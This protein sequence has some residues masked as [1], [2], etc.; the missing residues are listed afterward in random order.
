[1]GTGYQ[2]KIVR[3]EPLDEARRETMQEAIRIELERV[4]TAMSTYL[5][6][7]EL[8][9]WNASTETTPFE[10]SRPTWEVFDIALEA[11][12]L[13]GGALD[14][15]VGPLV[16]AWGFGPMSDPSAEEPSEEELRAIRERIGW[17]KLE[18]LEEPRAIRKT[19]PDLYCDLSA[20]AKGYAVDRVAE[21]LLDLGEEDFMVEVGGE[22]R[23]AGL[24]GLGSPWRIGIERPRLER[25]E[26]QRIVPISGLALATSGDYR[27]YREVDGERISHIMDPRSGRPI[28]HYLASVSVAHK[29]CAWADALATTLMVM[30]SEEGYTLAEREGWA[31]LFLVREDDGFRELMTPAFVALLADDKPG[32]D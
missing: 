3:A 2:V 9:L 29:S 22:V 27:N 19:R 8:S 24:N 15:T 21:V 20:V 18:L 1:M 14:V 31:V 16:N 13:S 30:G 4:N 32:D 25:G 17:D 11:S 7:S 28:R 6:D 23:A 10:L 12:R 26:V 5:E